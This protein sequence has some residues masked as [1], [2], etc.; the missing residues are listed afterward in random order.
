[1]VAAIL[2][3]AG[4]SSRMGGEPKGLLEIP[5]Q[6]PVLARMARVCEDAGLSPVIAVIGYEA[7]EHRHRL[8]SL[9]VRLVE[10]PGWAR[11]RTGSAQ[12]GL[13]TLAAD[14]SDCLLWPVDAPFVRRSTV[15][16]L[17]SAPAAPP[18]GETWRVPVFQGR[19]GHPVLLGAGAQREVLR[20]PADRPLSDYLREHPSAIQEVP[21]DDPGVV[22][23][24]DAPPAFLEA[25]SR[26][27][28]GGGD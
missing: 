18:S 7:Q 16:Y 6:G 3:A 26:F 21:V 22:D 17:L 10:H 4:G 12:A 13:R 8:S 20:Y 28:N 19:R 2:L 23:N 24:L 9:P 15:Q 5:A 14:P 25:L 11:G 1:M 27:C